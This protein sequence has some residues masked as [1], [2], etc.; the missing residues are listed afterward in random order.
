MFREAVALRE[1]L[2]PQK[3]QAIA[4]QFRKQG[5][6]SRLR[7]NAEEFKKDGAFV[8]AAR[9]YAQIAQKE[10]AIALL[11]NCF[12]HRC[13]SMVTVKAEPDFD[14]LRKNA[15]FQTLTQRIGLPEITGKCFCVSVVKK[16]LTVFRRL[17]TC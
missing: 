13:S 6:Q 2:N 16:K 8:E 9:C 4:E 7:D 15:R 11:K 12:Q 14:V 1:A 5:F 10:Q 3:S 17:A